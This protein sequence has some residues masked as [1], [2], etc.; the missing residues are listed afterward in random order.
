M[1]SLRPYKQVLQFLMEIIQQADYAP[2]Y[3]LP[4]E[5]MLAVKFKASRRSIRLA[6][7]NLIEQG[8]VKKIHGKGHF[9]TGTKEKQDTKKH[10]AINKIYFIVPDLGTNFTQNIL[11]GIIDFCD[12]HTI[13]VSIKIS[14]ANLTKEAQYINSAFSSDA[15]GIILFPIDYEFVNH[16]LLK[17]SANRYPVAVIDRYFTNINSSF[18]S[19]DNYNAMMEAVKFLHAKKHK[20]LLYLSPPIL[21][22]SV[23]E[24]LSGYKD[25]LKKYYGDID[26]EKCVLSL[27]KIDFNEIY[28]NVTE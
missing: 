20:H 11:N 19:T 6:Y 25:G 13:D 16:E 22:T 9:T 21:A 8:F 28:K 5:R 2:D 23:E 12:I 17:L 7:D 1:N 27:H 24:R 15:K 18:I 3:K 4:S 26:E 14:R 10:L